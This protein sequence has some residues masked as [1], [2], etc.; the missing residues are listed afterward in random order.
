[1]H[2]IKDKPVVVEGQIVIRPIMVVALTY[3]HRLLDGREAVTFLGE[4]TSLVPFIIIWVRTALLFWFLRI[5]LLFM[6][7][8][9]ASS[10]GIAVYASALSLVCRGHRECGRIGAF[11]F[12]IVPIVF[13]HFDTN[14]VILLLQ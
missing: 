9:G 2:A 8:V 14:A 3:D 13:Y 10:V 7:V 4:F 5:L 11:Y 1:M 6:G 12:S